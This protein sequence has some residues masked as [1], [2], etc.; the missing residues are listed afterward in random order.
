MALIGK[1]VWRLMTEPDGRWAQTMRASLGHNPSYTWRGILEALDVLKCG[2][3]KRIGDG[4]STRVW[5]DAWLPETQTGRIVSPRVQGREDMVVADLI[6]VEGGGEAL[7]TRVNIASRVRGESSFCSLCNNYVESI[8]HLFRDRVFAEKVWEGIRLGEEGREGGGVRDWVEARWREL[9]YREHALFMV[10]C[11]VIWEHRN[12]VVFDTR[13]VDVVCVIRRVK[14]VMDEME[15]GGFTRDR[16]GGGRSGSEGDEGRRAWVAPQPE[17]VKVN[18][19]AGTTEGEGMSVGVV[20]RDERGAVLWGVSLV[21]EQQWDSQMAEAVA[22]MEE[23]SEGAKRGHSKIV[24]ESDCL[25]VIE[26]LKKKDTG[27]SMLFGR[28]R[29]V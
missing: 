27:R 13:E 17:Y 6:A 29:V 16:H 10:G 14:D 8:L 2:W 24:M 20:C 28:I 19:D 9:G 26:R 4:L 22:I 25:S 1:Q 3:R 5:E 15:G 18:V 21:Q 23:I 11:W 7:A 12:K